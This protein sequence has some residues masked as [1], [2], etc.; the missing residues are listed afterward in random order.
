MIP[1]DPNPYD[2]E[3]E[4][5]LKMGKFEES[6]ASYKKAL[7]LDP[8]FFPSHIGIAMNTIL[9][10]KSDE[11]KTSLEQ[12]FDKARNNGERRQLHFTLAV[13]Y[14]DAGQMDRA[15][16]E[17]DNEY[18]IA[19]KMHDGVSMSNDLFAKG[20]IT[21]Y[22]GKYDDAK[23]ILDQSLKAL[24]DAEVSPETKENGRPF[25]HY[26]YLLVAVGKKDFSTGRSEV[27]QA[28]KDAETG[29]NPALTR[30]AHQLAGILALAE[31]RYTDA[32]AELEQAD[33][34]NP[35]NLYRLALAYKGMGNKAKAMEYC[36]RAAHFNSLPGLD[37]AFVRLKAEKML[38]EMQS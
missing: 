36:G 7:A 29:R 21:A 13:L 15:A 24:E 5:L 30:Q 28:R 19:D 3:A 35:N 8:A 16:R 34:Q 20:I 32:V 38:K 2:S 1:T 14:A 11:A 12:L 10:G 6:I 9:L 31:E 17:L 33:H 23:G 22:A 4:L 25:Y 18:A 26:G 37:F 27:E